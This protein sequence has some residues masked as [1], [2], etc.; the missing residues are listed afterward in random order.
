MPELIRGPYCSGFVNAT[1]GAAV[2][3][4]SPHCRGG[5]A[6]D[7]AVCL[8]VWLGASA[9]VQGQHQALEHSLDLHG[10]CET[11]GSA[12][13]C[14]DAVGEER[15]HAGSCIAWLLL[16]PEPPHSNRTPWSAGI[17]GQRGST[18]PTSQHSFQVYGV[19]LT[20]TGL[21]LSPSC[22]LHGF[23]AVHERGSLLGTPSTGECRKQRAPALRAAAD[24]GSGEAVA[25]V[26]SQEGS[27]DRAAGAPAQPT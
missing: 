9:Y 2:G 3:S 1:R 23:F 20:R 4:G 14:T 15:E 13:Q 27:A 21:P 5:G 25:S 16:S 12:G 18:E 6:Q 26:P 11:C 8:A 17:P 10:L 22:P 7:L 19:A 24:C